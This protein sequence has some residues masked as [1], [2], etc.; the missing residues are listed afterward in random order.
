[1]N[2]PCVNNGGFAS[3]IKLSQTPQLEQEASIPEAFR[4]SLEAWQARTGEILTVVGPEQSCY[5][6][7]LTSVADND[8]RCVPFFQFQHS[9]ESPLQIH[10]CQ[11]LPQKERFGL[12]L[13]KLTE[14]GVFRIVPMETSHSVTFA[15]HE[16][17]QKKSHRWPA[18]LRRASRQCRRALIPELYSPVSF[19]DAVQLCQEAELKLLLCEKQAPWSL[20]E[21]IGSLKPS[22]VALMVGPEGG[23]GREEVQLAQQV[24]ILP[25]SLGPRMLRTETA[26]IVAATLLQ[27]RLGDMN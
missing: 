24:G 3:I 26:A 27:G 20:Y 21:G 23:F 2:Q 15:E 1:L 25:V 19:A 6:A 11:A 16:Q 8:I 17:R 9:V 13:E 12:I 14:I 4:P 10:V 5:R 7:R 22:S 18:L